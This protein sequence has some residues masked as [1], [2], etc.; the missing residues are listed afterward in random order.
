VIAIP[1]GMIA[2]PV[3]ALKAWLEA[4][5]IKEGPVF[6]PIA[7]GE[8]LQAAKLT[9]GS[10]AAI[11]KTTTILAYVIAA[12]GLATI[13]AGARSFVMLAISGRAGSLFQALRSRNCNA[14]W[15]LRNGRPCAG[16]AIVTPNICKG[17]KFFSVLLERQWW[18][19]P[20]NDVLF[21]RRA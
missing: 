14:S 9:D 5:A 12:A 21:V 17:L 13:L 6:R 11:V 18:A 19:D 3:A 7:K 8:R 15:R 20:V 4:A 10:V 2:C 1:R 16:F